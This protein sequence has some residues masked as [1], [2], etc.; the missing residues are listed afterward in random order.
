MPVVYLN[1]DMELDVR[2]WIW[3]SSIY[4]VELKE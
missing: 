4:R 3:N 2:A 1:I